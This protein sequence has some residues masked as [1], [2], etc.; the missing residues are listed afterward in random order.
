MDHLPI[1][2]EMKGP[3]QKPGSP[4]KFNPAWLKEASYNN[5]VKATW[6]SMVGEQGVYLAQSFMDNLNHMKKSTIEW[7]KEKK[8]KEEDD[9]SPTTKKNLSLDQLKKSWMGKLN[10]PCFFISATQKENIEELKRA[11][12]NMIK[13][14]HVR[15]Y[16]YNKLLY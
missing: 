9:L 6:R 10:S 15:R 12:Y 1:M 13:E 7:A 3:N 4:F 14:L 8:I 11:L 2:L 16:P 5:L